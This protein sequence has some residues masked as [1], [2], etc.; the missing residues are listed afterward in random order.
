M[1]LSRA[2]L[3]RPI[4]MTCL[5]LVMILFGVN[6]YRKIGLDNMPDIEIPW[7]TIVTVYPGADPHE[8]EVDVAKPIENA[9]TKLDG[10]KHVYSVCSDNV[11]LIMLEVNIDFNLNVELEHDQADIV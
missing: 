1:F 8:I 10:L 9:V 4:A 3:Q 7:L 5:I 6:S 11:C 2:S